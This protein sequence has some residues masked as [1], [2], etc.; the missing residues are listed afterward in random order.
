MRAVFDFLMGIIG[1]L[2]LAAGLLALDVVLETRLAAHHRALSGAAAGPAVTRAVR[3]R[4][5]PEPVGD[6]AVRRLTAPIPAERYRRRHVPRTEGLRSGQV[7]VGGRERRYSLLVPRRAWSGVASPVLVV[8]HGSD[9][10]AAAMLDMWREIARPAG[11]ILVAPEA[12]GGSWHPRR[13]GPEFAH[14]LLADLARDYAIDPKRIYLFGHDSGAGQALALANAM[15][16]MW[17]AVAVHGGAVP[18]A[19]VAA[20]EGP[21]PAIALY[22]G[23]EDAV[24]PAPAVHRS[25]AALA[26]AGHDVMLAEIAGHTHWYFDIGPWLS[27]RAWAFFRQH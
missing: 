22:V 20:A 19:Q 27:D 7:R 5:P 9:G 13:D 23:T 4:R 12:F 6:Y 15:P 8:L 25:A 21:L 16:G 1:G 17:R 10:G 3:L 18:A 24:F 14:A 26:G 11:L 2:V